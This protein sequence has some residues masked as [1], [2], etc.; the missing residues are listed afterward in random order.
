MT[1]ANVTAVCAQPAPQ[2]AQPGALLGGAPAPTAP[3]TGRPPPPRPLAQMKAPAGVHLFL[4]LPPE[5]D[6][7]LTLLLST[8]GTESQDLI[9]KIK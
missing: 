3:N 2:T 4:F 1:R 9:I 7:Y 5:V 6:V 8:R